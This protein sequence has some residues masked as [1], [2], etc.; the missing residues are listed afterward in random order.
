MNMTTDLQDKFTRAEGFHN[1]G[2]NAEAYEELRDIRLADVTDGEA[3]E[4]LFKIAGEAQAWEVVQI[5]TDQV[6][7]DSPAA[8]K[9]AAAGFLNRFTKQLM[10]AAD[11]VNAISKHLLQFPDD[12]PK[13]HLN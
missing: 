9:V 1:L 12:K 10:D 4:L 11:V 7:S 6:T 2:M 13:T 3:L 8:M 5:V